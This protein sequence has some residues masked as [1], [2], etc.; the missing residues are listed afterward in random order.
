MPFLEL[1]LDLQGLAAEAAEEAAFELG[2]LSVTLTDSRDD[3][4]LEPAPGE[5]RLWPATRMQALFPSSTDS[6][7]VVAALAR[8]LGA[9]PDSIQ[10]RVVADRLWEREWLKDFHAMRF[11]QRLWVCPRHE[12]VNDPAAVVVL[13]DPGLAFGTGTHATTA[14]CLTWLDGHSPL[15]ARIIDF[16][17]GSGILAIAAL[18]L[19]A[20]R[21]WCHDIDPQALHAT[22]ENA[23]ANGVA[24][25]TEI[26]ER[27]ASLPAGVDVLLANILS[28]PLCELAETFA[29][30]V[31][32]GGHV[33]LSGLMEHQEAEVTAAYD[34][35]FHTSPIAVREGWVALQ[36]VRRT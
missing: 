35:W 2:A 21:A 20:A 9:A 3:A 34:A 29:A 8:Q 18:K 5:V 33:I 11:G 13:L 31:R 17:C 16:G 23:Q 32:P 7:R 36:A 6:N 24:K 19:G 30:R 1:I 27:A 10:P 28:G 4:V 25:A 22:A 26:C 14:L 12:V 15:G